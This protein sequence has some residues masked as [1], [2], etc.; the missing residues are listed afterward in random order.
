MLRCLKGENKKQP[1]LEAGKNTSV[2][3]VNLCRRGAGKNTSVRSVNL[4]LSH[5]LCLVCAALPLRRGKVSF[6]R[7]QLGG[8]GEDG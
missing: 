8:T 7:A 4:P 3:S 5:S 6:L 1:V 2:R